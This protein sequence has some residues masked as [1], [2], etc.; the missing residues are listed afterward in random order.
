MKNV[1]VSGR[2]LLVQ[3]I[4]GSIFSRAYSVGGEGNTCL[5]LQAGDG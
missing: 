1:P 5:M 3:A 2:S 4:I